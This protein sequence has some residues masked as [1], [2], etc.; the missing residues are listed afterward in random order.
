MYILQN[1]EY[2]KEKGQPTLSVNPFIAEL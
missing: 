2:A 1:F